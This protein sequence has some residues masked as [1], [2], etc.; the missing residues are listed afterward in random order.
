MVCICM[1]MDL[2]IGHICVESYPSLGPE[3][4]APKREAFMIVL[5]A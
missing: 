1:F 3:G 2:S 5:T 4:A